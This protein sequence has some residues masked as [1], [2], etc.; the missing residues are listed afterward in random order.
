MLRITKIQ[1]SPKFVEQVFEAN[2]TSHS[3]KLMIDDYGGFDVI[4]MH[5]KAL[6]SEFL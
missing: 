3:H 6:K 5:W 2:Y 4:A 1:L